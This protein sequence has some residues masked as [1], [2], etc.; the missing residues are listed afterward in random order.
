[1][2]LLRPVSTVSPAGAVLL[3]VLGSGDPLHGEP[4]G[5]DGGSVGRAEE[6]PP[7]TS[8]DADG[9]YASLMDTGPVGTTWEEAGKTDV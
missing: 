6:G 1:M 7:G 4:V 9:R 2:S 5:V 8:E 3:G